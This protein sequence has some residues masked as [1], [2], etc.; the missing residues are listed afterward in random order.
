MAINFKSRTGRQVSVSEWLAE[1]TPEDRAA[2]VSVLQLYAGPA[3]LERVKRDF[4]SLSKEDA[5]SFVK[6]IQKGVA[7]GEFALAE[8]ELDAALQAEL[9]KRKVKNDE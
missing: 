6:V 8:K 5:L 4:S 1:I 7:A 3:T 2:L 9:D